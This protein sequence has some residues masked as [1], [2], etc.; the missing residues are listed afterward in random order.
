MYA[1]VVKCKMP[2]LNFPSEPSW[3]SQYVK[4]L[5]LELKTETGQCSHVLAVL[6]IDSGI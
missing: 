3:F 6:T 1:Q 5:T 4:G 2:G